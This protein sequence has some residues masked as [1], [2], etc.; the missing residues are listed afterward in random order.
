MKKSV[1]NCII[2]FWWLNT[3]YLTTRSS[4]MVTI[5]LKDISV[6]CQGQKPDWSG[7]QEKRGGKNLESEQGQLSWEVLL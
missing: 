1:I 4:N 3:E 5:L 2:H 6:K 7:V